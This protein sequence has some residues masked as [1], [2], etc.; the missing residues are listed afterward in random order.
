MNNILMKNHVM[1]N[2]MADEK[3]VIG[4]NKLVLQFNYQESQS[5]ISGRSEYYTEYISNPTWPSVNLIPVHK[6]KP[7]RA[8]VKPFLLAKTDV[9]QDL[10]EEIMGFNYSQQKGPKNPV[11]TVSYYDCVVF[12]NRLSISFGF[13]CYYEI[14]NVKFYEYDVD[15][16]YHLS[17]RNADVKEI[18]T[19]NGFRIPSADE[20]SF[21]V[22][23][24]DDK[25]LTPYSFWV[26]TGNRA[27]D[28]ANA[29]GKYQEYVK[30]FKESCLEQ[31]WVSENSEDQTHPVCQKKP[32]D[33]GFYDLIGN[34]RK[35]TSKIVFSEIDDDNGEVKMSLDLFGCSFD[36]DIEQWL[37]RS[38]KANDADG[39]SYAVGFRVARNVE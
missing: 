16:D 21:A 38:R 11:E 7:N 2:K 33:L 17:I 27:E 15:S 5:T 34:V 32:N 37:Q 1:N 14:K 9:T 39:L 26:D 35:W 6:T 12:C 31:D 25:Q 4:L 8:T 20:F 10:F 28:Q 36:D 24:A 19:A 18:P 22:N 30:D 23:D 29:D 3:A 13:D